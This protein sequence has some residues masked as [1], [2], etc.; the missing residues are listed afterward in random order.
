MDDKYDNVNPQKKSK[1][2]IKR[3]IA[4]LSNDMPFNDFEILRHQIME[5]MD[6]LETLS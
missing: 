5:E 6:N 3:M 1:N 4:M 2:K